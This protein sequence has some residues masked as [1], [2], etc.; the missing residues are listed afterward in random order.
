MKFALLCIVVLSALYAVNASHKNVFVE[1]NFRAVAHPQMRFNLDHGHITMVKS[2]TQSSSSKFRVVPAIDGDREAVSIQAL[3][4]TYLKNIDGNL[5]MVDV[6]VGSQPSRHAASFSVHKEKKGVSLSQTRNG[7]VYY[8]RAHHGKLTL[9]RDQD[10][11]TF[12][13]ETTF[14]LKTPEGNKPIR[15]SKRAKKNT[16]KC[17]VRVQ[18]SAQSGP[19]PQVA[20]CQL[21]K[22]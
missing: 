16:K 14:Y 10:G 19:S 4:Q 8:V 2:G 21:P 12:D 5:M 1:H 6:V 17:S 18:E 22:S 3:D 20:W 13:L 11:D 9:D 15:P 7:V